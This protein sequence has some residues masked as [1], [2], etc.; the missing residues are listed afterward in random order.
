MSEPY[1]G[2]IRM[3][4]GNFPPEGWALCDGRLLLIRDYQPLFSLIGATYGGDGL[5]TFALPDLRGRIPLHQGQGQGLSNRAIGQTG[6]E[7]AGGL[8][9]RQRSAHS[10]PRLF[11]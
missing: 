9:G 6:G 7:E 5:N 8:A 10:P 2:E 3:F 4:G 11:F 1:I